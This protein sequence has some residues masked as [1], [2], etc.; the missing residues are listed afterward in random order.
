MLLPSLNQTCSRILVFL[1]PER[2]KLSYHGRYSGGV[3]VLVRKDFV[4]FGERIYFDVDN[5]VLLRIKKV[6]LGTDKDVMFISAYLP[7]YDSS[8]W[9]QTPLAYGLEII[10]KCV[11]DLHDKTDEFYLLLCGDLNAR[12][13]SENYNQVQDDYEDVLSKVVNSSLGNHKII[14]RMFLVNS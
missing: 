1:S 2:K 12:T 9:K 6:L 10:E 3:I 13:A 4:P 14:I 7:P 11:M 5:I 8:Y